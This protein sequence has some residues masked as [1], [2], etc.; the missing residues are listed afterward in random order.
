[1]HN[2][3]A[4]PNTKPATTQQNYVEA[5]TMVLLSTVIMTSL[6]LAHCAVN[7]AH[8]RFIVTNMNSIKRGE[9]ENPAIIIAVAIIFLFPFVPVGLDQH[10][11]RRIAAF[12]LYFL[13]FFIPER[14]LARHKWRMIIGLFLWYE[15]VLK[16][17]ARQSSTSTWKTEAE[18]AYAPGWRRRVTCHLGI[19]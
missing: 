15:F 9:V 13:P 7:L 6:M 17:R 4:N 12:G 19:A 2:P 1:M 8:Y 5:E 18:I 10:P 14:F 3:P 11:C 16:P